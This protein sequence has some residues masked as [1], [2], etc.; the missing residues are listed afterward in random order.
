MFIP[1][2]KRKKKRLLAS[3]TAQP[4]DTLRI[5]RI[6]AASRLAVV[7]LIVFWRLIA[8]PYDTSASLNPPCLSPVTGAIDHPSRPVR[9]PVI[10]KAIEDSIV[11]DGVY[12]VRIAECG[13]E[14][15]QSYAFLPL[16]PLC[17]SF[18]ARSV[19]APFVPLLGYRAVLGLSA[20]LLN[21]LAFC[22]AS[23][24]FY[25]LSFIILKDPNHAFQASIFFCF[26]PASIFYSSVYSESLYA[27]LSLGGVYHLLQG[28][29]TKAVLLLA[30]SGS[31]RSNGLLNAGY[32]CFQAM[33]QACDA[34][35]QKK[36]IGLALQIVSATILQTVIISLPFISFQAY[37]FYNICQR[38]PS[39]EL[40]P[41]CKSRLPYLYGF[42]QGHYWGV[43]FLSYFQLKQLPNFFLASPVLLLAVSSIVEYTK[44]DPKFAFSLGFL[45]TCIESSALVFYSTGIE[46]RAEIIKDSSFPNMPKERMHRSGKCNKD[47][48]AV[49]RTSGSYLQECNPISEAPRYHHILVLPFVLHLAFLVAVA[50]FVMHVQVATRFLSSSPPI[51][52]FVSHLS[53]SGASLRWSRFIWVYFTSYI[54]LGSLL[55]SN[56]Y[57]F[58]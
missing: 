2:Q 57:P 43:G 48:N 4:P 26:N 8:S 7:V 10:S 31:A 29:K 11:W 37:G 54:L 21:N 17:I 56:F 53:V 28:S 47:G 58:T 18:L 44:S 6:A 49:E 1:G 9:W 22:L 16:L 33:H 38:G 19:F 46:K 24:Y 13:Y 25:W 50:F 41:W 30:F 3:E 20:Y 42:I 15:E 52:W 5:L 14:Y 36:K 12:F 23:V 39:D 34:I 45:A 51:Y 55:F 40:R 35:F 32:F 27:L